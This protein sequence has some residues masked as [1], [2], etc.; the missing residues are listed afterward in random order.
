[1]TIPVN[2]FL[3]RS[4]RKNSIIVILAQLAARV[5]GLISTVVLARYLTVDEFGIY[6]MIVGS[7]VIFSL[8][9]NWGLGSALQRFIPEY[10]RT[11]Q[12]SR[13][14]KTFFFS[15]AFRAIM[16]FI[17]IV[18]AMLCFES[19]AKFVKIDG[20]WHEYFLFCIGSYVFFQIEFLQIAFNGFLLQKYSVLGQLSYVVFRLFLL[21][22]F[23]SLGGGLLDVFRCELV[24]YSVICLMMWY[25]FVKKI[26]CPI[27]HQSKSPKSTIERRR[28][29]RYSLLSAAT[30]PGGFLFSHAMDYF[31]IAAM[32]TTNQL[33]IYA[34]GSRASNMLLSIMPQNLL[35]SVIRPV[36]Y[37][38]YY[39]VEEKNLELNRMFRTLVV[40]IA[41]VLIPALALVSMQAEAILTFVFKSKFAEAT[42]VFIVFL[43]FNVS[44]AIELPSD[45]VLQAIE[46]V[47]FR[48]YAQIFALYNIIAA[49]LLLPRFGLAGVAFATGS[50]LMGKC[51]F[52][53]AAAHYYTG[54]AISC[55][56]L[57]K[58][59]MNTAVAVAVA[60]WV[61]CF[62][63]SPFWMFAS[64][65]AGLLVYVIL[66]FFNQFFD[67]REKEL[68]NRFCKRQVFSV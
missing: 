59:M 38:R 40:L 34:L 14:F 63:T 39:S 67:N 50:A 22:I 24:S 2:E 62:G 56:A 65:A 53:F 16:G 33:G 13:L 8:F 4:S 64:L 32:A 28:L 57:L 27:C 47:Q 68:I 35:Q 58:I 41:A 43:V 49:V 61:G 3:L 42:P 46:K 23:L 19:F 21:L 15:Q 18:L 17:V 10:V 60:Y 44:K 31:V 9:T 7:L 20:Y 5:I 48:L 55:G 54:I 52:W 1:M 11:Q 66:A 45:L 51:V 26:Y 25:L 12:Y 29:W 6:N 36:F 37:H 30:I